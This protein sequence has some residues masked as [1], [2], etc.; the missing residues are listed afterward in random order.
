MSNPVPRP[1]SETLGDLL[2]EI[3]AATPRR[4]AVVFRDERLNYA[5]LKARADGFALALLAAGV[6]RGDRVALLVTNRTEWLIAAFGAAKIG[7]VTAAIST[8]STPRELGWTLEHC[9]ASVLVTLDAFRGRSFLG[10]LRDLCPELAR[11]APGALHSA[12]LPAL[13][14]VVAV[15]GGGTA[16]AFSL[17]DFFAR[18]AGVGTAQ[19]A[20]AQRKVRPEDICYILYTSGS[21]AAPKGVTLAHGPLIANGFDIGGRMHLTAADLVWLAVPLFWS[22]GSA[23][24]LPALMTHGGSIVLQ[25]SFEPGEA[26]A[27]IERECCTVYYGMAN[28]ARAMREHSSH[29]GRRLG[30][31]RSGLTIGPPEDIAMTIEAVGAAELCNVYGATETYGNCAVTDAHDPLDQRLHSQGLALPGMTIRAVDRMTRKALPADEVGEL[32]VDGYVTPAYYRAPELDAAAFD[33]SGGFLTGDLGSIDRGGRV[34][35]RGRL[36]EM[37]KTGGINVAPLEVEEVLLQHPE[38]VQA[39]V[40]G[41]PDAA[42]GEIVAAAVESRAGAAADAAAIIA[43]CRDRL[44]SYKVPVLLAFYTADQLPR[45][46]TGK[47]HKP[48]LAN[49]FAAERGDDARNG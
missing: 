14:T 29:P 26:I 22:F 7:A 35:F 9:G 33:E 15:Q 36:K 12:K 45:T 4:L 42:K 34:R 2:D 44:A 1:R 31:M 23:N 25:E 8:F 24:A 46:P 19:L 32:V 28:M 6:R 3:A 41:L 43:F 37:I 47:I 16:G 39:H 5:D 48:S 21:T 11:S 13:H 38:I 17:A 20:D 27:L 49:A 18:G 40:V 30:A 10:A